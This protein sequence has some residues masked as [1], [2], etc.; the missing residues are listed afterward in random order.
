M[1]YFVPFVSLVVAGIAL[2]LAVTTRT[3]V[4]DT[5][6]RTT[7][8]SF[9]SDVALVSSV[10]AILGLTLL[11]MD[12]PH[13]VQLLPLGDILDVRVPSLDRTVSLG[14]ASNVLLFLPFGAAL[15]LRGLPMG[16]TALSG[17][18]FPES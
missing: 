11:P 9:A 17:F 1:T 8:Q 12:G 10:A 14:A 4:N 18:V 15:G 3:R 5:R 6:W 2:G 16:Q 7:S 13:E